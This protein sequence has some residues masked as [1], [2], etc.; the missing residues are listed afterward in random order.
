MDCWHA[1]A[2]DMGSL[3]E[4][5]REQDKSAYMFQKVRMFFSADVPA[6]SGRDTV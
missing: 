3:H 5:M 4:E 2:F 6:G 1:V